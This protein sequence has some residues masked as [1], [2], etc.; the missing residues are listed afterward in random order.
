MNVGRLQCDQIGQF[1]GLWATFQSLWQQLICPN[2]LTFLG[3]FCKG[4]KIFNLFSEIILG[5]FDRHLATFNWSHWRLTYLDIS[6]SV[7]ILSALTN[8]LALECFS[9]AAAGTATKASIFLS[10]SFFL[11][12]SQSL[13]L[14]LS[15]SFSLSR[16]SNSRRK[17]VH[18]NIFW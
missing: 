11:S 13:S 8:T 9:T 6:L 15:L 4:V 12:L 2:L 16:S 18:G 3:N 1:I 10:L 7:Q 17:W 5:N 14:S